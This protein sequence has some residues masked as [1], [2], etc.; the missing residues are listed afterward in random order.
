MK[1]AVYVEGQTELIFVREFLLK[2]YEYDHSKLGIECYELKGSQSTPTPYAFSSSNPGRF[3]IIV[4]VGGD[5]RALS[6]ALDNAKEHRNRG[7]DRVLVLRDM[8]S[9]QYNSIRP[10]QIIDPIINNRFIVGAQK[11][12]DTRNFHDFV[13]CHFAIMEVEAWILGMGWFLQKI[14]QSLTQKHLKEKLNFDLD[15][16]PE[17]QEYH[18]AQRLKKIYNF[19]KKSYDKHAHEVNSI[20]SYLDKSDFEM[21]LELEKCTSFN[22]FVSNLTR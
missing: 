9:D 15:T 2:W 19:I 11:A 6:K 17:V 22:S 5:T 13:F 12:I 1:I 21:L 20:M 10:G 16:D 3:Y 4:N 14:D 7:F 8:Y 18:P